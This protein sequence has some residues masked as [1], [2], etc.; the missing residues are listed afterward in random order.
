[1]SED[2]EREQHLASA[3]LRLRSALSTAVLALAEIEQSAT[4][5]DAHRKTKAGRL[6]ARTIYGRIV[7]AGGP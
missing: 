6:E 5:E 2:R 7:T 1:M 4:I 3:V